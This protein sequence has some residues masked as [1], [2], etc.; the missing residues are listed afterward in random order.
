MAE[1]KVRRCRR[2][3]VAG[4]MVQSAR[5]V[6]RL[7][8][9]DRRLRRS[10]RHRRI[11][12]PARWGRPAS[13][14]RAAATHLQR[15]SP[16]IPATPGHPLSQDLGGMRPHLCFLRHTVIFAACS[17]RDHRLDRRGGAAPGRRGRGRDQPDRRTPPITAPISDGT[18]AAA[19]CAP[20]RSR[21]A[22][23]PRH[24][25]LPEPGDAEFIEALAAGRRLA[26]YLDLPLQHADA[27]LKTM[28]RGGS[29][30][31]ISGSW[32]RCAGRSTGSPARPDRR[33][34]RR[35]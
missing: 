35:D 6:V 21:G 1:H 11:A 8:P 33:I 32:R 25:C 17:A 22:L 18:N 2:L 34:P 27:G 26:R 13:R 23:V 31:R 5:R 14:P 10:Q 4:C 7:D 15:C 3:V 9:R 20:W 30:G 12:K 29:G 24:V 19:R 28:R 16:R